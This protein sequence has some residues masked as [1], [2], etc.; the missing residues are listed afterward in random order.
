MF[1]C[2]LRYNF[3][4]NFQLRNG[5]LIMYTRNSYFSSICVFPSSFE[6]LLY[7]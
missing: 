3:D 2:F 1:S 4:K 6:Y 7:T 5:I